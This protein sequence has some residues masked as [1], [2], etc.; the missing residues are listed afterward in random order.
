MFFK[1]K[2]MK[3]QNF[4]GGK[5]YTKMWNNF[6]LITRM[7][8]VW[9]NRGLWISRIA[10][11]AALRSVENDRRRV[12]SIGLNGGE[13]WWNSIQFSESTSFERFKR[14]YFKRFKSRSSRLCLN[15]TIHWV[16]QGVNSVKS[17]RQSKSKPGRSIRR[18]RRFVAYVSVFAS[19]RLS[20]CT[21]ADHFLNGKAKTFSKVLYETFQ[22]LLKTK[23][24]WNIFLVLK[25][26]IMMKSKKWSKEMMEKGDLWWKDKMK[27]WWDKFGKL[28][29][30]IWRS[31]RP[32]KRQQ[33]AV[34]LG[35]GVQN[36]PWR[37][38]SLA[39]RRTVRITGS[40][41]IYRLGASDD[42]RTH[43][44]AVDNKKTREGV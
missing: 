12:T 3:K 30:I 34:A 1:K 42:R 7:S 26:V 43:F 9:M 14:L 11:S 21:E 13:L 23:N 17:L 24:W 29:R 4:W 35:G 2:M 18:S 27:W 15:H 32:V 5:A 40:S 22:N 37:L 10:G 36:R 41:Q 28:R 33:R 20:L 38:C 19:Q 8:R 25:R 6:P 44:S 16:L 39:A 31:K